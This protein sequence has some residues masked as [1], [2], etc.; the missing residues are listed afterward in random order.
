MTTN[1]ALKGIPFEATGYAPPKPKGFKLKDIGLA[2]LGVDLVD[3]HRK[4]AESELPEPMRFQL[5]SGQTVKGHLA[6]D[7]QHARY[8]STRY[9]TRTYMQTESGQAAQIDFRDLLASSS[10]PQYPS[11]RYTVTARQIGQAMESTGR[12]RQEQLN[13][14]NFKNGIGVVPKDHTLNPVDVHIHLNSDRDVSYRYAEQLSQIGQV[15]GFHLVA[16]ARDANSIDRQLKSSGY[17]NISILDAPYGEAWVEDY[18]EPTLGGGR[19]TPAIFEDSHYSSFTSQA[20]REGRQERFA[21]LGLDGAFAYHGA[22]NQ[23]Q[24]QRHALAEALATN[25]PMRQ[26]LSYMEGGNIYTG[27]RP[28]GDGFVL[29]GKDSF[30][31]SKRLLEK[32]TGKEWDDAEVKKAI[33]ADL[34]L[35][36]ENVVPVEQPNAFHLDM[37]M[38]SVAPGEFL[39]QD[40]VL[41]ANQ[42]IAWM[43]G[44]LAARTDLSDKDRAKLERAIDKR[45]AQML[46]NARKAKAYEDLTAQDLEANGFGVHRIAGSFVD[47]NRPEQDRANFF[48]ARHGTNEQ[49]ERFSIL[50]GGV[51]REEAFMAETIFRESG[52]TISHIH[53]LDP[54]VTRQTL[55]LMG[56]LKC[57]TKP[58]GDLV[59]QESIAQPESG[60]LQSA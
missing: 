28:N 18:S 59:S 37:R 55:D 49:G 34:G 58:G 54:S 32:Q 6:S 19:V 23:G 13:S 12:E 50:M 40:S 3:L 24:F 14:G 48:N 31:V 1:T 38:T 2:D 15:E 9:V 4:P 47:E 45:G 60:R 51:P 10:L 21:H 16:G 8:P 5:P 57:R 20:I 44:D 56:G 42:Q 36:A 25:A 29:V 7:A 39:L 35:K 27:T 46:E 26:A 17:N 41:A 33:A 43:K 22:V 53:F 52:N 30:H 11:Q